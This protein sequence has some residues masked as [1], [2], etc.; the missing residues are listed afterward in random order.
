MEFLLFEFAPDH[1]FASM[2]NAYNKPDM[3]MCQELIEIAS[4]YANAFEETGV[5]ILLWRQ[6]PHKN[7]QRYL[8]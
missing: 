8:E 7:M 3:S 4:R 2:A 6:Q 5:N 1:M